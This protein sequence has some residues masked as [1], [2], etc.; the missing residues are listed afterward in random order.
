MLFYYTHTELQSHFISKLRGIQCTSRIPYILNGGGLFSP[1]KEMKSFARFDIGIIE[2]S[3]YN[4]HL[5]NQIWV[6]AKTGLSAA[7]TLAAGK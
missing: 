6:W 7:I 5:L 1:E 3:S 2:T 4:I